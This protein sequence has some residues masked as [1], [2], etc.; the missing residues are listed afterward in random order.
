MYESSLECLFDEG[1]VLRAVAFAISTP[2][3]I[4]PK[5]GANDPSRGEKDIVRAKRAYVFCAWPYITY[6]LNLYR[7]YLS[8]IS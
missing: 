4:S 8:L 6:S 2:G 3:I 1:P 5:A 7:R